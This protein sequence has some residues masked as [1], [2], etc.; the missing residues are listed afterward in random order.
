DVAALA[1]GDK[2][3]CVLDQLLDN[4]IKYTPEGG[5]VE[6]GAVHAGD[7][8]RVWV[9]D[10][11]PGIEAA[12]LPE[13][14]APFHQLDGSSTRRRGGTG[15]G[16]ALVKMIVEAHQSAVSVETELGRGSRFS[17]DLAAAS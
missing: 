11:G 16:L 7:H 14:F 9:A 3:R 6:V 13:L 17:F 10:T 4:A 2:L 1:D 8:V 15:L 12:R 5:R